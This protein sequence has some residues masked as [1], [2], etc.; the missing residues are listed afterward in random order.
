[1]R[2]YE[3]SPSL[4]SPTGVEHFC[5]L[6]LRMW[7]TPLKIAQ[8]ATRSIPH[9]LSVVLDQIHF[10]NSKRSLESCH[11]WQFV[12]PFTHTV[13]K[14]TCVYTHTHTHSRRQCV[15]TFGIYKVSMWDFRTFGFRFIIGTVVINTHIWSPTIHHK[16]LV[17]FTVC[18]QLSQPINRI[19]FQTG[20]VCVVYWYSIQ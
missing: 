12:I 4:P 20:V 14:H 13:H 19:T 5:E 2:S 18:V 15:I 10:Y 1:M 6:S 3:L 16:I 8:P 7:S 17:N 11:H 9:T